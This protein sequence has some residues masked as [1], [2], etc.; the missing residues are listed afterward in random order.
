LNLESE[1]QQPSDASSPSAFEQARRK[2]AL[3]GLGVGGGAAFSTFEPSAPRMSAGSNSNWN[4]AAYTPPERQMPTMTAQPELRQHP[5][6][7]DDS[8]MQMAPPPNSL[9]QQM[10]STSPVVHPMRPSPF[11]RD[12][13]W[14]EAPPAQVQ[15]TSS[16]DAPWANE[17]VNNAM[18]PYND[19]RQRVDQSLQQS[20][21]T[22]WGNRPA[23]AIASPTAGVEVQRPESAAQQMERWNP[24]TVIPAE[25]PAAGGAGSQN[26]LVMP[27][28]TPANGSQSRISTT[29]VPTSG[30]PTYAP[31]IEVPPPYYSNR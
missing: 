28:V 5:I 14:A 15:R 11:S 8:T 26:R 31:G 2:A 9:G 16:G 13:Q 20:M 3:M 12:A 6:Y 23:Q 17:A 4:G 1:Q 27:M 21:D 7:S 25:Y 24:Q 22:A 30:Q 18:Q 10:P 29:G 19:S